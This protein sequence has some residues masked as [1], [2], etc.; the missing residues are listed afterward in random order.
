LREEMT[1]ADIP[2]KKRLLEYESEWQ[3]EYAEKITN[4]VIAGREYLSQIHSELQ[5]KQQW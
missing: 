1:Y 5:A 4:Y 3:D 2:L